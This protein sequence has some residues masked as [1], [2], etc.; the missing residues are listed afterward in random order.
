MAS[1]LRHALAAALPAALG[2]HEHLAV[3]AD[4]LQ[5]GDAAGADVLFVQGRQDRLH[6]FGCVDGDAA[7]D[8][9]RR[10]ADA[11]AN[12]RWLAVWAD[13]PS[14]ETAAAAA[15]ELGCGLIALTR[16]GAVERLAEAKPNPGTFA[17]AYPSIRTRW[18]AIAPW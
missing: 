1:A 14:R 8:V 5:P 15:A 12:W 10:V 6:A 2:A 9:A 7:A 13:A 17:K 3:V 11:P 16:A 18:R 4:E